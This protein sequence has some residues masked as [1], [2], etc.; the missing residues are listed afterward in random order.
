[1]PAIIFLTT[2]RLRFFCIIHDN[3]IAENIHF[4]PVCPLEN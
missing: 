4:L 3:P 2:L 1:M